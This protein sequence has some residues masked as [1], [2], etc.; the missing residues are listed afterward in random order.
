MLKIA[1]AGCFP[2]KGFNLVLGNMVKI[3]THN[4]EISV[5]VK[6]WPQHSL[7]RDNHYF[8]VYFI[9]IENKSDYTV[10]LMRRH[11]D[12]VDSIGDTRVVDGEGVVGETP[13]L[14]PGERFEYNSGCNLSSD[15]GYM[16]GYYTLIRLKDGREFNVDIPRFDLFVP[17]RL[18]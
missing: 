1:S 7:P 11:W 2:P 8:F 18:N 13:V 5:E 6:Y 3:S 14:E 17:A 12:I 10:Q 16:K 9:A 15:I 4:I